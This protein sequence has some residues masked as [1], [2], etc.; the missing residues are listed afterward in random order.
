M[1]NVIIFGA[2]GHANVII[3]IIEKQN[4]YHIY[5]IFVDTPGMIG[6]KILGYPVL[7]KIADFYGSTKGIIAVGDNFNRR[8]LANKIREID[9]RFEFISAIHPSSIIGRDVCIGNGTVIAPGAILNTNVKIGEHCIVNTKASV[10]H[11]VTLGDFSTLAP[12]STIGGNTDI[13]NLSTV[14]LGASVIHKTNIGNNT[15]IGAGATVVKNIPDGV[16]AYGTPA[17]VIR[18]REPNE[19]YV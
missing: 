7:D 14:S 17:Q 15:V 16:V 4:K 10:G 11:D 3:D 12:G 18:Y 13:G 8:L 2:S 19:K 5:G 6:T 9:P 1:E